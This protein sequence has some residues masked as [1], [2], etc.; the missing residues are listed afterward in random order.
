MFVYIM[1]N[2][3]HAIMTLSMFIFN[4]KK[5]IQNTLILILK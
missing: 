2:I 5:H 3:Q 4:V 1:K